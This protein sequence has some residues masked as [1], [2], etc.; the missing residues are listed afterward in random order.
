MLNI[1]QAEINRAHQEAQD[2]LN[3]AYGQL[4]DTPD[5]KFCW[6]GRINRAH[7]M[8][9]KTSDDK[10]KKAVERLK[11]LGEKDIAWAEKKNL[12]YLDMCQASGIPP[13]EIEIECGCPHCQ[14]PVTVHG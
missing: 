10:T 1:T 9:A 14:H 6:L 12:I 13:Q 11:F 3:R 8:L 5:G 2:A 7:A 4:H